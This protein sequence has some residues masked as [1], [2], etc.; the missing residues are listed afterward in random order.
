MLV[1]NTLDVACESARF[2]VAK[3]DT[4]GAEAKKE[5]TFGWVYRQF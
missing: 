1:L 2:Q 4:S 5:T 3:N